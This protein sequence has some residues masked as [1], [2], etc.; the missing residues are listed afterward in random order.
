MDEEITTDDLFY[1]VLK[2]F[3]SECVS[4]IKIGNS[5]CFWKDN[6]KGINPELN[7]VIFANENRKQ[8]YNLSILASSNHSPFLLKCE[9]MFLDSD[10]NVYAAGSPSAVSISRDTMRQFFCLIEDFIGV[11]I[12]EFYPTNAFF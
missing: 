5:S 1:E 2:A 4:Y 8:K 11:P 7:I 9:K 10:Q 6:F 12:S 3:K